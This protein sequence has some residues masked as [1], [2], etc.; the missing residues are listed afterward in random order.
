MRAKIQLYIHYGIFS[1]VCVD[2]AVK[3]WNLHILMDF[4]DAG[5]LSRL[6]C[7]HQKCFRW[8]L[9]CSLARDIS[10][11]V[12]FVHSK[13]IMHRD[14]TS[15]VSGVAFAIGE[16]FVNWNMKKLVTEV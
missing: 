8:S 12:D 11:A 3:S 2:L 13:G 15:M 7:D 10:C 14:L 6:I 16:N 5:S 1:G 9:R 4:C